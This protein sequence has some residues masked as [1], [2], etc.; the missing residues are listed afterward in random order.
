MTSASNRYILKD[1]S[2]S[3]KTGL[4]LPK[5]NDTTLTIEINTGNTIESRQI[6]AYASES[7]NIAVNFGV[8]FDCTKLAD[9]DNIGLKS[10]TVEEL[11]NREIIDKRGYRLTAKVKELQNVGYLT[12][13]QEGYRTR[14]K[15]M[16]PDWQETTKDYNPI[17]TLPDFNLFKKA[18]SSLIPFASNEESRPILRGILFEFK[19]DKLTLACADGYRLRIAEFPVESNQDSVYVIPALELKNAFK[20]NS[21]SGEFVISVCRDNKYL[22]IGDSEFSTMEGKFPD[23]RKVIPDHKHT[24]TVDNDSLYEL[25]KTGLTYANTGKLSLNEHGLT[26]NTYSQ[27]KGDFEQTIA[28]NVAN[29]V[30]I[31]IN[32]SYLKSACVTPRKIKRKTTKRTGQTTVIDYGTRLH[33]L[34]IAYNGA[35]DPLAITCEQTG[36]SELTLIMLVEA[37]DDPVIDHPPETVDGDRRASPEA[38][39]PT[40]VI[41]V[42]FQADKKREM[43]KTGIALAALVGSALAARHAKEA[44]QTVKVPVNFFAPKYDDLPIAESVPVTVKP[45]NNA[46][47][48][49]KRLIRTF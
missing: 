25:L 30:T 4:A 9:N 31:G 6:T 20:Q 38:E 14:I 2:I 7:G 24:I 32:L 10:E 15:A 49:L 21:D 12:F 8:L 45:T 41:P 37:T 23:Y 33:K 36:Y 22:K 46:R 26:L 40:I 44:K 11:V 19:P 18:L 29:N 17:V 3:K 35:S 43:I 1:I 28:C 13:S 48:G 47:T 5:A 27:E 34:T 42:K 16:Y 39:S